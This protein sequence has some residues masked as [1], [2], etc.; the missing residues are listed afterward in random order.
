MTY[1]N[2]NV[3]ACLLF[4]CFDAIAIEMK[5]SQNLT[6]F[7]T[8]VLICDNV[9]VCSHLPNTCIHTLN[10]LSSMKSTFH[11]YSLRFINKLVDYALF[12]SNMHVDNYVH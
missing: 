6:W 12:T 7:C 11:P 9:N 2:F 8:A 4:T 5:I 1:Y 10:N 3:Y